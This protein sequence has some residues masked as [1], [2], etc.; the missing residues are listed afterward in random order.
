MRHFCL[1]WLL[2]G[3]LPICALAQAPILFQTL[4]ANLQLYPRNANNQADVPISGTLTDA[5]Y[6]RVSVV[7][8]REGQRWK[9][10][11]QSPTFANG[12][13][14]FRLPVTIQ[15][16]AAEYTFRVFIANKTDSVLV[17][18]R[19]RVVCGDVYVLYGQSNAVALAGIEQYQIDD[20]L[21]RNIA[22]PYQSP[23]PRAE[24]AW[25]ASRQP[26]GSV[27]VLGL[28]I[29]KLILKNHGIPTCLINGSEGGAPITTL[30]QRDSVGLSTA[31]DKLLFRVKWGGLLGS[32]KGIIFKHG[33]N[34]AGLSPAGY[35]AK[36]KTFH[37]QLRRDF[38]AAPRLYI[39][40]INI[41]EYPVE[42]A[43]ELR[44]F[45]RRTKQLY[46][47]LET[48]ATVGS[49]GYDGIHYNMDGNIK[50]AFEQ[51]R[52]LARDVYGATDVAQ[53]NSPDV[54]KVFFNA[55]RDSVTLVF[56]ADQRMRFPKDTVY[57]D[58]MRGTENRIP[59]AKYLYTDGQSG[60]VTGGRAEGQRVIL[61]LKPGVTPGAIPAKTLTYLPSFFPVDAAFNQYN[62]PHLTNGKGMRA[63]SF[64]NVPIAEGLPAILTLQV[65]AGAGP[66][67]VLLTW[68]G[69]GVSVV[70]ERSIGSAANFQV[71]AT[72]AERITTYTDAALPNPSATYYYRV[73]AN[74][75]T[76]EGDYSPVVAVA[77]SGTGGVVTLPASPTNVVAGATSP[78]SI[79]LSW[80][81]VATDETGYEV[82]RATAGG[83]FV[84]V[85]VLGP[86]SVSYTADNLTENTAYSFRVRAVNAA[87][88]SAYSNTATVSTPYSL[89]A[90]PTSLV[91]G[92]TSPNSITL[93][94]QDV[95]INE[96]GYQVE[97][98]TAGG[99]F[100]LIASLPVNSNSFT[101]PSLAENT[102][103]AFRVRAIN[104]AGGS[105][106]SNTATVT[107]PYSLPAAPTS[108]V[109]GAT[110][111]N[112]I[113][114]VWQDVAI[115][116]TGYQVERSTA[117]GSFSLIASVPA[118]SSTFSATGLTEN[119]GYVFRIRATNP[120]GASPYSNT[121][122]AV[123]PYSLPAAP[124]SL[125]GAATS[126]NSLTLAW[127]DVAINETG[128][129][130]ERSTAGGSF[131]LIA[132]LPAN[133]IAF[134]GT[135]LAENTV[136]AFRVR[137]TNPAGGSPYSNTATVTTPYSLPL[138]P[139][140]LTA[141]P[142]TTTSVSLTWEDI[143]VNETS[144]EV[145][146]STGTEN[147]SVVAALPP[148]SSSFVSGGL[149]EGTAYTFR[150]RAVNPAGAS[151]YSNTVTSFPLILGIEPPIA[152]KLYP[153]PL[154]ESQ[155]LTVE[156]ESLTISGLALY[157]ATGR[158]VREWRGLPV[159]KTYWSLSGVSAGL[160]IVEVQMAGDLAV[161]R[162]L[163][164]H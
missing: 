37:D 131:S 160:Y 36:F 144:Y 128:Y 61:G 33:E 113:T 5:A 24:V 145:E 46:P 122:T 13:A 2:A 58:F 40:Q 164:I 108:L 112:S 32:V 119:T 17:A 65:S 114:L 103:Y 71:L 29:Q 156:A 82:E 3:L 150:V 116:E 104:P 139:T 42:G 50:I 44:D 98:S 130:L 12:R 9:Y 34:E 74:S 47:N 55:R 102:V 81:D 96:T 132:S 64:Y 53:I 106:Y 125:T 92:A 135:G 97:R 51:Y 26:F 111:P 90:A 28:E 159:S 91:A 120:A 35:D 118:N 56:D 54:R 148:N 18:E 163:L 60:L 115:N 11:T 137:A 39:G 25:Y 4:P 19:Q 79:T 136:Y 94:W 109:A 105:P 142:A 10:A 99:S 6:A 158:L 155:T 110:S 72:V 121:A 101:N 8:L 38:G 7:V 86:N 1:L 140:S 22:I 123:T 89:P 141:S 15:A 152:I 31:Y 73:R 88:S 14:A 75:A 84:R 146:R 78:T 133:S 161:R 147:F 45:Q 63:F 59:T 127:Q 23:N 134:S 27:G 30:T 153:N 138:G 41:L 80:Q 69:P 68:P 157:D 52:Q 62:G 49:P 67:Q 77:I 43:G 70:V 129:Q 124:G 85:S 154:S 83:T 162:K 20:R 151:P 117:G 149:A 143:A 93:V 87:G 107:T 95:A 66:G 57:Y 100:S 48:I 126:P 21:L 76:A 16:E